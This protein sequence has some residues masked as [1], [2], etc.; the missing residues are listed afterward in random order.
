[1]FGIIVATSFGHRLFR[2]CCL[3]SVTHAAVS[4]IRRRPLVGELGARRDRERGQED[5][6]P[7]VPPGGAIGA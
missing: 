7:A 1:M 5:V 4:G 2:C 6:R 3:P